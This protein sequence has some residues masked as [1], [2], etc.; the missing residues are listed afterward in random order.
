MSAAITG[1]PSTSP[2][3]PIDLAG[4]NSLPT[5]LQPAVRESFA[6]WLQHRAAIGSQIAAVLIDP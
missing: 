5:D 6:D 1:P 2:Q 3:T 4:D